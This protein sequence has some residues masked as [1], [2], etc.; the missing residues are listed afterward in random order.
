MAV[1]FPER[2]GRSVCLHGAAAAD[3]RAG[4]AADPG[5]G[6]LT[7]Q[8]RGRRFALTSAMTTMVVGAV[9]LVL[10][11]VNTTLNE[12]DHQLTISHIGAGWQPS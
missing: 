3:D 12:L 4:V 2:F 7:I 1:T 5:Q 8:V 10:V 9:L 6:S 11:I